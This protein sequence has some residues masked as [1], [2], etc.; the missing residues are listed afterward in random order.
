MSRKDRD[1]IIPD[2]RI[3]AALDNEDGGAQLEAVR[4]LIEEAYN[5]GLS[6]GQ[7]KERL[8]GTW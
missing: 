8:K 4:S 5:R 2:R 6:A 1:Q 7:M 3:C